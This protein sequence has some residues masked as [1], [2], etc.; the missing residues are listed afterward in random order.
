[1]R[2][3]LLIMAGAVLAIGFAVQTT[4]ADP[5]GDV[6]KFDT[7]AP[8]TGQF[9]GTAHPIRG[10]VGGGLPWELTSAHGSL[11]SDGRLDV[12]V[13]G[14]V[15]ARRAPV[16][17][18]L[19]GTNPIAQFRAIV[20]CLNPDAPDTPTNVATGLFD[21]SPAGDAKIRADVDLPASCVAPIVFVTSPANQWFAATG[22]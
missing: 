5:K 9:V 18:G 14:L 21:A 17:A 22:A 15:L 10:V 1:M 3:V 6:L 13:R 16:P 19:Q 2:R 8:V 4:G 12:M 20:S 7:M 11:R